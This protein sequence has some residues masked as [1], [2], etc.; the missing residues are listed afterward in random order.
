MPLS[1]SRQE[2]LVPSAQHFL[3]HAVS[4]RGRLSG[5]E[6]NSFKF[7]SIALKIRGAFNAVN[8]SFLIEATA[9]V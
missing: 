6:T 4:M 7:E 8:A 1:G 9:K 3:L 5:S 2:L